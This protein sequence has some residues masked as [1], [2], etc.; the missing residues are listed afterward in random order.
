[1][2]YSVRLKNSVVVLAVMA[3]VVVMSGCSRHIDSSDPVRSLP[4][5]TVVPSNVRV[6]LGN[7]SLSISWDIS[8]GTGVSGYRLFLFDSSLVSNSASAVPLETFETSDQKMTVSNLVANRLYFIQV[9]ALFS[10]GLEGERSVA[11]SARPTYFSIS[12]EGGAAYINDSIVDV[13][14]NTPISASHMRLSE[15]SLFADAQF[16][17]FEAN[18]DFE[19]SSG[20]G[21]KLL[22]LDLQFS[23]GS[24]SDRIASDSV[25]LDTEIKIDQMTFT[26]PDSIKTADTVWFSLVSMETGGFATVTF[27][28][29]TNMKLFDDGTHG[30]TAPNNGVY[31]GYFEVPPGFSLSDGIVRGSFTDRAGNSLTKAADQRLDIYALPDAVSLTALA[32]SEWQVNL[33][34]TGS[35]SSDFSAYRIYRSAGPGV[36]EVSD[37][38]ATIL[39]KSTTA[40]TDTSL[41]GNST[42][43]YKLFV[44][45]QFGFKAES[46]EVSASTRP[47]F[48]PDPVVLSA[49]VQANSE[50]LL[51]WTPSA[52]LDFSHYLV[53]RI[54]GVDTVSVAI[55]NSRATTDFTAFLPD[56]SLYEFR[57]IVYDR[58]GQ[59]T[60]SNS[61]TAQ[62]P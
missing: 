46:N 7:N 32:L 59:S 1:M 49:S 30:D 55:I 51:S 35:T 53:Q 34:W 47:D 62:S 9:A 37:L 50:V 14:I 24:T 41:V 33:Q 11:V 16:V 27:G 10:S 12:I 48:P 29:I 44:S 6:A 60:E 17:P 15:D 56:T 57:V 52:E 39:N 5:S 2:S 43:Y 3:L 4:E 61:V 54:L 31:A 25:F 26:G 21:L 40:F 20:D 22:Y 8:D 58:G 13:H 38:V 19:L 18:T 28:S 36:S 45:D 23:D 42:Y